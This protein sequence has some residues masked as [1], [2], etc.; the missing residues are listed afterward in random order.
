MRLPS[1]GWVFQVMGFSPRAF[2][3]SSGTS[4]TA[5][6]TL[7]NCMVD[8]AVVLKRSVAFWIVVPLMAA[9]LNLK[10]GRRPRFWPPLADSCS[11]AYLEYP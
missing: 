9:R 1:L 7:S 2:Q 10:K 6:V 5:K 8:P 3:V 4:S 11:G